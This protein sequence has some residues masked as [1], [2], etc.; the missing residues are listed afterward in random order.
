MGSGLIQDSVVPSGLSF[1]VADRSVHKKNDPRT[2]QG[3]L[4]IYQS[5]YW[6]RSFFGA[7]L[8]YLR[9]PL[10]PFPRE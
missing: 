3:S 9:R 5:G 1:S 7:G 6:L 8:D 10:A 4:E 2:K